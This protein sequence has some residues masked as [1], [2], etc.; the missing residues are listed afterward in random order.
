M[1]KE[2]FYRP[3]EV[4]EPDLLPGRAQK[5]I[6]ISQQLSMAPG[7]HEL[8]LMSEP[9]LARRASSCS[10]FAVRLVEFD[11]VQKLQLFDWYHQ[12]YF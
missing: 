8:Q 3:G 9:E 12:S 10:S 5:P 11:I 7:R 1:A 6:A 4:V 2:F